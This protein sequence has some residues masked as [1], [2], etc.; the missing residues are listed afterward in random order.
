MSD[1]EIETLC[2]ECPEISTLGINSLENAILK[3]Y[4]PLSGRQLV[5]ANITSYSFKEIITLLDFPDEVV[6]IIN[7]LYNAD[8]ILV[9]ALD[10]SEDRPYSQAFTRLLAERQDLLRDKK[11][12]VFALGA[13]YYLDATNISKI[14]AFFGLYNKLPASLDVA[15]RILF[16]EFPSITGN[17]PVSVPG[18]NYDLISA[19][20]PNPD[21]IFS[22]FVGENVNPTTTLE[23][24]ESTPAAPVYR[25]EEIIELHTGIIFDH[26]M[27]PV[28]DGTP[29][30]FYIT[31][32]GESTALP[33]ITTLDGS[34]STSFLVKSGNNISVQAES[35]L[36]R[37]ESIE[38]TILGDS[39]EDI[40]A[41]P[42]GGSIPDS[43]QP[44]TEPQ[45][46]PVSDTPV[47]DQLEPND[48]NW[49]IW[50]VSLVII[51]TISLIA[52]QA[53]A[54]SGLV[55]SGIKWGFSSL[56]S[57]LLVYNYIA[58]NLP[59]VSWIFSDNIT[60]ATMGLS[61]FI[62]TLLGWLISYL[63]LKIFSA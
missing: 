51:I 31:T 49:K 18:I 40:G 24:S 2:G 58:L 23:P 39:I 7:D 26:N 22:L 62:G 13:P 42:N 14:T 56:I 15:A 34:A 50:F 27:N 10:T 59:G 35:S 55:R 44:P 32:Q 25:V 20:S 17:L 57:G 8:W 11:I 61:V 33:Q 30:T 37:S 12:I 28:P 63:Y 47:P 36:A 48:G 6:H 3:L 46:G 52:Y 54:F 29:V 41:D 21:Q 53:G 4:G 9:S 60:L 5:R 1:T 19:T 16:K 45:P 38:I 43:T